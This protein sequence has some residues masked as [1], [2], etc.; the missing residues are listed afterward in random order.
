[1]ETKT[2][3]AYFAGLI[4]GE[5]TVDVYP[6][7]QGSKLRPVVK[8]NMTCEKTVRAVAAHF[9]GSVMTKKVAPGHKP[10]WHWIV[11]FNRAIL[12][13]ARIRPY[14]ITKAENADRILKMPLGRINKSRVSPPT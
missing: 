8:L 4:D 3:D 10:Q 1:M 5:G 11:T 2:L 12:V 13:A 7:K 6:H 14:M 9:G